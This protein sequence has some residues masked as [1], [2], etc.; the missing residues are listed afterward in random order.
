MTVHHF[1]TRHPVRLYVEL[2]K[3]S[4]RV[5]ATDTTESH[6]EISGRDAADVLV[7]QSGDQ[8]TVV[9]PRQRGGFLSGDSALHVVVT[10]PTDSDVAV[11]S[12]SADVD[13]RGAFGA[14]QVKSGSGDVTL[15]AFGR[16]ATVETGS[17]D[18]RIERAD[19]ELRIKSGSG[20]VHVEHTA[21][22]VAVS[23]GSGD[24]QVGTN[25][26][27]ATVKTGSGDLKVVEATHDVSLSTGSGDL[28]I[29]TA[30]R[31]RFTVKGASGDVRI[32]I[33]AGVPV[34][35]DISTITGRIHSTLQG[36]GQPEE[37]VDHVEVRTKT[38]S[39]DVVLTEV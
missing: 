32:G 8:L 1:E 2:G 27:P 6:V 38:V 20:D 17:G 11:K 15:E 12:G 18:I 35:T 29:S 39:G 34:W 7:E 19:S 3:G 24:V 22:A 9:A 10:V 37:G 31:G 4:V 16:P 13:C 14:G 23:T 25:N 26:G 36:A 30:S 33:P 5:S 21:S 28:H